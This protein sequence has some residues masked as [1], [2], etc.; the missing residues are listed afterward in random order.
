MKTFTNK[1]EYK[2]KKKNKK[3]SPIMNFIIQII[4]SLLSSVTTIFSFSLMV[5]NLLALY[6]TFT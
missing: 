3:L 5:I 2:L 6:I 4:S 1:S